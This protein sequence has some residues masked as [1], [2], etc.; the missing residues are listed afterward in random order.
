MQR[1]IET[2]LCRTGVTVPGGHALFRP[3]KLVTGDCI[4]PQ[5]LKILKDEALGFAAQ[6][7]E[8]FTLEMATHSVDPQL[9]PAMTT[10]WSQLWA[11]KSTK[12]DR[13]T[14][15]DVPDETRRVPLLT[16]RLEEMRGVG[17]AVVRCHPQGGRR[18]WKC[19][20]RGHVEFR[21]RLRRASGWVRNRRSPYLPPSD[22]TTKTAC[23]GAS[24]RSTSAVDQSEH[25]FFS[26]MPG[27]A[28][29]PFFCTQQKASLLPQ[30][31]QVW[32]ST[33]SACFPRPL[34]TIL[35]SQ[36]SHR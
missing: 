17:L 19:S 5:D 22:L 33:F 11:R 7:G 36:L 1:F 10:P 24:Q 35:V 14:G 16:Y 18:T 26:S 6:F 34:V 9:R 8:N 13:V 29:A 12:V 15:R 31:L 23:A 2:Y 20:R 25:Y 32:T 4:K 21:L 30:A 28:P 3:E 27:V